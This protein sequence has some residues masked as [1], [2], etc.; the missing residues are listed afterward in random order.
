M[1]ISINKEN[2]LIK[3]L[4]NDIQLLKQNENFKTLKCYHTS[5]N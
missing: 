2:I 5:A 1:H 3:I 4:K